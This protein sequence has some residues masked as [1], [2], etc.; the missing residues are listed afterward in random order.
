[1]K[2]HIKAAEQYMR[3]CHAQDQS[4]HDIAH[5]LRVRKQALVI[6]QHYPDANLFHI[7]MSALLHDTIDDKLVEMTTARNALIAFF[8]KQQIT[9]D[10]QQAILYIIENISYR[11]TQNV[12]TLQTIEAQIVQDADRLDA[13]GAIGIARTFQFAGHFNE[14]MWTGTHTLHDMQQLVDMHALPP[15]AIKHFFEKLL[16]LKAHINTPEARQVAEQ[17]HTFLEHFLLQF[18]DEWD[19]SSPSS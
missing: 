18:F 5:V 10:D 8:K 17:R 4:G 11:K 2:Q 14:P 7:E 3:H 19:T 12:G 1:M 13:L 6:A 16:H 9:P 15:S